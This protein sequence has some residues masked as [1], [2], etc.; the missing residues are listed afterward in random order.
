MRAA[1]RLIAVLLLLAPWLA[2]PAAAQNGAR[3]DAQH[4]D[5]FVDFRA[6]SSSRIGHTFVVYGRIDARGR[7]LE[8][9]YA[10]LYPKDK[11]EHFLAISA[12]AG[13]AYAVP[14]YIGTGKNDREE[15]A[16]AVYRRRLSASG[17]AHLQRTL[18]RLQAERPRW[19]LF[20]YN[21]NDFAAQVAQAMG[22]ITP[23]TLAPPPVYVNALAAMNG[24]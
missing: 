20:F 24:K 22:M 14:A 19:H 23:P 13:P 8:A 18:R 11:Y 21:C 9:R 4:W 6:R 12:I 17:Y 15:I 2:T 16:S 5:Y 1:P 3:A 7:I 10:G